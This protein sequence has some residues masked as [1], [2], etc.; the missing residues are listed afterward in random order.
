MILRTAGG[1]EA[2]FAVL[3]V[4]TEPFRMLTSVYISLDFALDT[5][6]DSERS[7]STGSESALQRDLVAASAFDIVFSQHGIMV[8]EDSTDRQSGS[9]MKSAK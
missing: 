2:L 3:L 4:S 9:Q 6:I 1:D 5:S 8:L 7:I